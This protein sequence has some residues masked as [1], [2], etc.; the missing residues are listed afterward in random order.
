MCNG[1]ILANQ[2]AIE[3]AGNKDFA[4]EN[5]EIITDAM[6]ALSVEDETYQAVVLA[7]KQRCDSLLEFFS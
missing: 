1:I 5:S 6:L 3:N 2:I 7:G 4:P